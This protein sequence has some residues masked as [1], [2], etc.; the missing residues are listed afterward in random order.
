MIARE[1]IQTLLKL[2]E[3]QGDSDEDW[4]KQAV[5]SQFIVQGFGLTE[6]V[7]SWQKGRFQFE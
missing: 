7:L 2:T 4:L 5:K 1:R 6:V 3:Q